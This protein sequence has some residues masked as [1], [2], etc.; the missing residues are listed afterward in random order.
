ALGTSV[1]SVFQLQPVALAE[2]ALTVNDALGGRFRLGLGLS[3]AHM[4]EHRFGLNFERPIRYL[5]EYLTILMQVLDTVQV[6][7]KGEMLAAQTTLRIT[8]VRRPQVLIA[9]L[10]PQALRV[11]GALSDG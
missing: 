6:D 1:L 7:F 4:V 8:G 2:Q 5:R 11:A 9:A 3:H 10:G